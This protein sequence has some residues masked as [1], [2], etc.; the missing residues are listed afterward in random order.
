MVEVKNKQ[1]ITPTDIQKFKDDAQQYDFSIFISL[2][3]TKLHEYN[4][5]Y[6]DQQH[7]YL[8]LSAPYVSQQTFTLLKILLSQKFTS[9]SPE[10][11]AKTN[12]NIKTVR[13]FHSKLL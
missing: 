3:T 8:Y 12:Q 11:I 10:D 1:T 5:F 6:Y 9:L 2:L 7:N 4:D 13:A